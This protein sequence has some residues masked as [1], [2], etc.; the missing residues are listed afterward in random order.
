MAAIV[1]IYVFA[2]LSLP[3]QAGY[4]MPILPFVFLLFARFAERNAFR[5]FCILAALGSFVTIQDGKLA[6]GAIFQ[7]HRNGSPPFRMSGTFSRSRKRCPAKTSSSS[8]RG[9]S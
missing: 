7:D 6:A 8:A 5:L 4:L 3:D 1:G 9:N 2:F